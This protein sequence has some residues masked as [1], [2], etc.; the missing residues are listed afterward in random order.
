MKE[1]SDVFLY[2]PILTLSICN[3]PKYL[4]IIGYCKIRLGGGQMFNKLQ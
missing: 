3:V 1:K 2:L 4:S